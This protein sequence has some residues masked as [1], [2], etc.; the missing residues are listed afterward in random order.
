MIDRIQILV[1]GTLMSL[2]IKPQF[3]TIPYAAFAVICMAAIG[4]GKPSAPASPS[5]SSE[6]GTAVSVNGESIPLQQ[7]YDHMAV[8][9]TAQVMTPNGPSESRVL[10][11]FGLQALQ[12]VVDQQVLLQMAKEQ[13]VL[14]TAA[15]VDAEL[16]L[17]TELRPDY[18]KILQTEGLTESM[19]RHD[20]LVGLAKEHLAMKGVVIDPSA[21]DKYIKE[22]PENFTEP[23][24]AKL[25]YIQVNSADMKT[26]VDAALTSGKSFSSVVSQYSQGTGVKETKG[27]YA[28]EIVSRMPPKLQD[29]VKSSSEKAT[30]PWYPNGKSFL[31]FYLETKV[32]GKVK[33]ATPAEKELV[34][35][36]LALQQGRTK[37]DFDH[38]FLE[39]LRAAKVDVSIPYLKEPWSRTWNQISGSSSA[40][41]QPQGN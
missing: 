38:Q 18:I 12:D 14:P 10:G 4:C 24:K 25:Y 41:G 1:R 36:S 31:K 40:P 15:D 9:Q 35:R 3:R 8:K 6:T 21:V 23:D 32:T 26:K 7:F 39:K 22:H 16:K 30:S 20:L 29:F 11:G 2:N 34:R 5:A 17:Q 19:I 13:N 33:P 37:N 27:L 28:Q